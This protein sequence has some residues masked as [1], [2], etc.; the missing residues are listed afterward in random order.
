M[1]AGITAWGTY[2]PFWRLER[3]A[4][5]ASWARWRPGDPGR[6]PHDEDTTTLG[7]EA[8]QR[9]L[10]TGPW[11][12]RRPGPVPV[13]AGPG[14]SGQD[15]RHDGARRP[16]ARPGM[17]GLRLRR[18]VPSAVGTLSA[19]QPR[20]AVAPPWPS[21][22]TSAPAW[23]ARPRSA[24]A[25]TAPPP[26]LRARPCGRR[27]HRPGAASDEFLDRWR[28]PGEADSHVWEERFGEELYVPLAREAFRRRSRTPAWP[29]AT[30]T[31]PSSPACMCGR[32]RPCRRAS[33][34]G[35]GPW[36][37]TSTGR[38]ATWARPRPLSR[39]ATSS[40][41]PS[42]TGDR[43]AVARRRGRRAGAAHHRGTDR[44]PGGKG[45]GGR[46]AGGRAGGGRA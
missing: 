39:C 37:P 25:A 7:V 31:T 17:R 40:S 5:G 6:G 34:S 20:G 14:L 42:R 4:I 15:E 26:S 27:A 18:L 1:S 9:A 8:G 29:K 16:G 38:S 13:D 33:A 45:R 21:S 2:L 11:R 36:P 19:R 23:P 24:T 46:P 41:G 43:R 10:A 28:V 3:S 30:S 44:G 32:S 12:S 22:R 35:K